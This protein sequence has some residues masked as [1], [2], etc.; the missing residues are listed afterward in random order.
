MVQRFFLPLFLFFSFLFQAAASLG[1]E[2][3]LSQVREGNLDYRAFE[4]NSQGAG[5]RADEANLLTRPQLYG[6]LSYAE[7]KG[8]IKALDS[9]RMEPSSA[10]QGND[11]R[12]T[13]ARLG[14]VEQFG[15]GLN[16]KL[17]YGYAKFDLNG[18][19]NIPGISTSH[20]LVYLARPQLEL[21]IPLYKNLLGSEIRSKQSALQEQGK[22]KEY[23]ESFKAKML[24]AEAESIYWKLSLAQ[25]LVKS[26][27]ENFERAQKMMGWSKRRKNLGLADEAQSLQAEANLQLRQ[28]EMQSATDEERA[29]RRR[30][31]S[32][33]GVVG[34]SVNEGLTEPATQ[35]LNE[36]KVVDKYV[37]REDLKAA[38]ASLK[39]AKASAQLSKEQFKPSV[40]LVGLYA[41]NGNNSDRKKAQD[42]ALGSDHSA[43]AVGLKFTMPLDV[44]TLSRQQQGYNLEEKSAELSVQRKEF[45]G[46]KDWDDLRLRFVEG[47][48]RF[49]ILTK[50]EEV[51]KKKLLRE[52][53]LQGRGRSTLFQVLQYESEY[54]NSQFTR[55]R[56]QVDLLSLY[57]L[58][59]TY[60]ISQSNDAPTEL[61]AN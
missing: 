45:E 15:F 27:Q 31:N 28:L 56:A 32:L 12:V 37:E 16:A 44:F 14:V 41:W 11:A 48:E 1:L 3:F 19:P 13:Q 20:S 38:R 4:G 2:G 46:Q 6:E 10:L 36:L 61:K 26:S 52:R 60:N 29:S 39:I 57:A 47:R 58:L 34:D 23:I 40:D 21:S 9:G 18:A 25:A 59:K 22:A 54:A 50:L 8:E 43:Y 33:R 53:D 7:D 42:E 24:L 49:K 17:S 51:Q 5:L 55:T 35:M 30:F